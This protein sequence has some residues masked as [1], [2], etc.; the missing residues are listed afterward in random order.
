MH[1]PTALSASPEQH[2]GEVYPLVAIPCQRSDAS[3]PVFRRLNRALDPAAAQDQVV[4]VDGDDLPRGDGRLGDVE[5]D[6][7]SLALERLDR[8]RHGPMLGA[9]LR[10]AGDGPVGLRPLPVEPRRRQARLSRATALGPTVTVR[11]AGSI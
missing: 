5:D 4:L 11:V 8:R 3:I 2:V 9:N 7:R 10:Q 1:H 6:P